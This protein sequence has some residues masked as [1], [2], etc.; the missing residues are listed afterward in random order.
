VTS[1]DGMNL[2]QRSRVWDPA[3][4]PPR[5]AVDPRIRQRRID[6]RRHQGRRRLVVAA[7]VA[8]VAALLGGGWGATRTPLL[9]VD[10]VEVVGASH[11]GP[12]AVAAVAGIRRGQAMVD[13]DV[14]GARRR[15]TALPWVARAEVRRG[16]PGTVRIRVF[17]RALLA[18]TRA[19][20]G[21]WALVD[22]AG[23]VLAHVPQPPSDVAEL[24]GL[25][26]AGAP[27]TALGAPAA[28]ALAVVAA[29]PSGLAPRVSAV[30]VAADGVALRL[31]PAGEVRLGSAQQLD[32]KLRA[33][34]SVLAAVDGRTVG[35]VDVRIPAAPVLTR[36]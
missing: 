22:R 28:A 12:G 17:E 29:L 32:D 7:A 18:V 6:V 27:G 14:A 11:T 4:T 1:D 33:A 23:R 10:R 26:P 20:G 8:A 21:A 24:D 30:A 5:V 19:D 25:P 15:V 36:R 9:D 2:D 13:V 34:L 35:T 31:R 16:W 3:N